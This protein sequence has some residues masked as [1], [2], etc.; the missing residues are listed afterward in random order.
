MKTWRN[1]VIG[2]IGFWLAFLAVGYYVIY[3]RELKEDYQQQM[4]LREK[5]L[6]RDFPLDL[7]I[8]L[9]SQ[10]VN[11][12]IFQQKPRTVVDFWF[13]GCAP[14][15]KE[16]KKFPDY[17]QS[18][19]DLQI[20]SVNIEPLSHLRKV[21]A[22]D[23][24]YLSDTYKEEKYQDA[25][26][27]GRNNFRG[28]AFLTKQTEYWTH[29]NKIRTSESNLENGHG[30]DILGYPTY[31][32]VNSQGIIEDRFN[33]MYQYFHAPL[34]RRLRLNSG[35]LYAFMVQ[36]YYEKTSITAYLSIFAIAIYLLASLIFLAIRTIRTGR[37]PRSVKTIT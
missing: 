7:I 6:G 19:P 18:D 9:D 37:D 24:Q 14:C 35:F 17:I 3:E 36:E 33:H 31:I 23:G 15:I 32:L 4:A 26:Y 1:W 21:L 2:L 22:T 10:A 13:V 20:L 29:L 8:D 5:Y 25:E 30:L 12:N 11:R 28:L 27:D 16:M 34:M